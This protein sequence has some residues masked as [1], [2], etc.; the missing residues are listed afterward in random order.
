VEYYFV[1]KNLLNS[2]EKPLRTSTVGQFWW[3]AKPSKMY[4][5]RP[6]VD[7]NRIEIYYQ[8]QKQKSAWITTC[9]ARVEWSKDW[10][11]EPTNAINEYRWRQKSYL[12]GNGI[13]NGKSSNLTGWL[14][15]RCRLSTTWSCKNDQGWRS[16]L[17]K[18][19]RELGWERRKTVWLHLCEMSRS[20]RQAYSSTKGI[21]SRRLWCGVIVKGSIVAKR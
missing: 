6:M 10:F 2:K 19:E 20:W 1:L 8:V 7:F 13:I 4:R 12:R 21:Y 17:L 9:K 15:L 16:S 3:G 18:V 14:L 5:G 11:S